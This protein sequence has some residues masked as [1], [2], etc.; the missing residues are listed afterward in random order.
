MPRHVREPDDDDEFEDSYDAERDYDPDDLDTYPD[1]LY[2]DD[3]PPAVPCR[4]CGAEMFEDAEQCP[5][6]GTYQSAE[7]ADQ[8]SRRS[9]AIMIVLILFL[10]AAL[11]MTFG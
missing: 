7:D 10:L 9:P 1:G 2:E 11:M 4:K 6:C 3:G 8:G 5:R